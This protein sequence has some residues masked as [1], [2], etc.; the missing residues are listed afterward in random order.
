MVKIKVGSRLWL[1]QIL[2]LIIVIAVFFDK[3]AHT[4]RTQQNGSSKQFITFTLELTMVCQVRFA[5][6][7]LIT[8]KIIKQ[9]NK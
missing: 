8:K 6:E 5:K 7:R 3:T 1:L 2:A 4:I 9:V